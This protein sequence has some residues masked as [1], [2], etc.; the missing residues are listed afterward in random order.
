MHDL[1]SSVKSCNIADTQNCEHIDE[2]KKDVWEF[3]PESQMNYKCAT[4]E[5]ALTCA[6]KPEFIDGCTE[7]EVVRYHA[8]KAYYDAL[9]K[10]YR[11]AYLQGVDCFAQPEVDQALQTCMTNIK[12]NRRGHPCNAYPQAR[13]CFRTRVEVSTCSQEDFNLLGLLTDVYLRPYHD[14]NGCDW[15]DLA[16]GP[17]ATPTTTITIEETTIASTELPP[18]SASTTVADDVTAEASGPNKI[19]KVKGDS[20][21]PAATLVTVIG[22]VFLFT[23]LV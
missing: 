16:T 6:V 8:N 2:E 14:L 13:K 15:E 11:Y 18:T 23:L 12:R 9:C 4:M 19:G 17:I 1:A 5:K 22:S 21:R 10:T 20:S 7:K 3:V